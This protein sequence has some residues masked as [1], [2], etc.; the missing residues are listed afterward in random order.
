MRFTFL[1]PVNI[2]RVTKWKINKSPFFEC[3]ELSR[4]SVCVLACVPVSLSPLLHRTLSDSGKA[5]FRYDLSEQR[6]VYT[7]TH[8]SIGLPFYLPEYGCMTYVG[9]S[10]CHTV[11]QRHK[12]LH[13]VERIQDQWGH[14]TH[15]LSCLNIL[16]N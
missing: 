7:Q 16:I 15:A 11:M 14:T 3:I 8:T 5:A 12:L 2:F 4:F 10:V 1:P 9:V 13:S 6:G